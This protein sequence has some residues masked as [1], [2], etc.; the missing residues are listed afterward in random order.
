[1]SPEFGSPYVRVDRQDGQ[2][3]LT[4]EIGHGLTLGSARRERK[5]IDLIKRTLR[6]SRPREIRRS[7]Q[8]IQILFDR[9]ADTGLRNLIAKIDKA[10]ITFRSERLYPREVEEILGITS[11]ERIRWTKEGR[12]PKSGKGSFGC[13]SRSIPFAM[14]PSDAIAALAN[15]RH[16]IEAWRAADTAREQKDVQSATLRKN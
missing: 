7:N 15:G 2:V 5:S 14:H 4:V 10:V 13:G 3:I 16:I 9:L 11:R 8:R 1:V 6:G 12:I